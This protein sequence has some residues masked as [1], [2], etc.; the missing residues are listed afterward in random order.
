MKAS[1]SFKKTI[2]DYLEKRGSIDPL[3]ARIV[4]KPNKNIDD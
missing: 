1:T 2:K 4:T 3:F